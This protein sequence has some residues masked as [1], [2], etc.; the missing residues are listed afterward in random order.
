MT[1]NFETKMT[2]AAGFIINRTNDINDI[3][4]EFDSYDLPQPEGEGWQLKQII[5]VHNNTRFL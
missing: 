5:P 3:I 4:Q 1:K 2:I